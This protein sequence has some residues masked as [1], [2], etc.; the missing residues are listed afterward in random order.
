MKIVYCY[1]EWQLIFD[2]LEKT[3][4]IDFYQGLPRT[5]E[6]EDLTRDR[7]HIIIVLDDL[8]DDV[9]RST[10]VQDMFTKGSHH[11]N[12][13]LIYLS[14]NLY[15]QGKNARSQSLNTHY[16]LLLRNPRDV[17]QINMLAR[18]TGLGSALIEAYRDSTSKPYGYLLVNLSPHARENF[19]MMTDILPDESPIVYLPYK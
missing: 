1:S 19:Q 5:E 17:T 11:R 12:L 14:Q 7:E 16:L 15:C 3:L 8:M 10:H 13:T 2:E 6:I 4:P 9:V 18:Q